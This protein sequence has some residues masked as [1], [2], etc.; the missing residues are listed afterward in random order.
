L[1]HTRPAGADGDVPPIEQ[2]RIR[3]PITGRVLR[4]FEESMAVVQPGDPRLERGDPRDL[5]IVVDVLSTDA[6]RIRPG[7]RVIVEHW[8]GDRPLEAVVRLVEPSAFTK[9]SALGVE[10]QRV[11]VIAD[12]VSPVEDRASLGD[13]FRVEV[14]IVM[15]ESPD[16]ATVPMAALFSEPDG[17]WSVFAARDG[18]AVRTPVEIGRQNGLTAE[19]LAGLAPG[20][21]VVAHPSDRV[22]DGVRVEARLP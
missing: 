11:N 22:R 13:A 10:E 17:S 12:F 2:F 5:E 3:S 18:R 1:V 20:D 14:R 4:L 21:E 19:I 8:G 6:V 7:D 16:V 15:W 9:I